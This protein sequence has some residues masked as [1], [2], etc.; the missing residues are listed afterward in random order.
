MYPVLQVL[1]DASEL[2]EQLGT[3]PKFWFRSEDGK[4]WLFKEGRTGTGE[5]WAE[6]ACAE[7]ASLLCLPHASYELAEWRGRLGVASPN[8]V[9][10]GARL[11]LANE[12]LAKM[13]HDYGAHAKRFEAREHRVVTA[14]AILKQAI[15]A[16][17]LGFHRPEELDGAGDV[18]VGYLL[19]DALVGNQ[20]RHHENWGFVVTPQS[21]IHLAP[22]FDH[23]SSLGRNEL[24]AVRLDRLHT[25]D[26]GRSVVRYVERAESAFFPSGGGTRPLTTL[27]AFEE[28]ARISATAARYWLSRLAKLDGHDFERVF[29]MFPPSVISR[30]A[31]DFALAILEANRQRL[32]SLTPGTT[33]R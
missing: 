2:P 33:H 11:V 31:V 1:Q 6:K 8:F 28:G 5:H 4:R 9:P 23:A 3:K 30:P 24:D 32:L 21:T 25:R 14:I 26:E 19:L 27:A 29:E 15:V 10:E 18:F 12:V 16:F 17:P 7:I 22:T 13:I 20:D